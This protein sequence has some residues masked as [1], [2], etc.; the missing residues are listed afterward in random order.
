MLM[1]RLSCTVAVLS[2]FLMAASPAEPPRIVF[3][4]QAIAIGNVTRS[5]T[6]VVFAIARDQY[7]MEAAHVVAYKFLL[8]DKSGTGEV[9][10]DFR[11]PLEPRAVWAVVDLAT[12][13]YTI[14]PRGV[15]A[16][17][18]LPGTN[19]VPKSKHGPRVRH[20]ASDGKSKLEIALP[21][22]ELLVVRPGKGAWMGLMA[23]G[24]PTDDDLRSNGVVVCAP[25]KL[26]HVKSKDLLKLD[27]IR[28]G[29][30][31]IAIDPV[32]LAWFSSAELGE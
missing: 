18:A 4:D 24:G 2:A 12:G 23:D 6:V 3:E 27:K 26:K 28:K 17:M 20:A 5:G 30:I 8:R 29:D 31:V 25:E 19:E 21:A 16:S 14:V 9:R 11:R 22:A 10:F 15:A 1:R 32:T 13:A 7:D